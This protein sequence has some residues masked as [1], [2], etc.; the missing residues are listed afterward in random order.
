MGVVQT[1]SIDGVCR[2]T[3][4]ACTI[5]GTDGDDVLTGSPL[6]D[7]ICGFGGNDRLDGGGGNDVL[8]GGEGDDVLIG[9]ACAIGG[10]GTDR[11]ENAPGAYPEVESSS[12]L[13]VAPGITV[14]SMPPVAARDNSCAR[15]GQ[16]RRGQRKRD[17]N[18]RPPA[19][20]PQH[21]RRAQRSR[22]PRSAR[23]QRLYGSRSPADT[24]SA[25]AATRCA[26]A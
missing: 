5:F 3:S 15:P 16:W 18:V 26:C 8:L 17:R 22:R 21:A 10:P 20:P 24:A 25:S 11:A 7:I 6:D 19:V 2:V 12:V 4:A 14:Q 23:S 1:T 13:P 9:G